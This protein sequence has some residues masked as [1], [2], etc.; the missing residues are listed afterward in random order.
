MHGLSCFEACGMYL[1]QGSNLCLLHWQV[2]SSLMDHWE[3]PRIHQSYRQIVLYQ[4]YQSG[5]ISP[6][7]NGLKGPQETA[8]R[9]SLCFDS[10]T[11]S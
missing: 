8:F 3:S 6:K 4:T 5:V 11:N 10:K 9:L 1:D 2:A 7:L